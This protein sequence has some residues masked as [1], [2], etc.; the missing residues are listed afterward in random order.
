VL[1]ASYSQRMPDGSLPE[2][3]VTMRRFATP[4]T[5]AGAAALD[6]VEMSFADTFQIGDVVEL[7]VGSELQSMQFTGR[8]T[9]WRP[10]GSMEIHLTPNSVL[11]YQYATSEPN[12]RSAKGYDSAPA[13]LTESGPRFSL[14][15][16]TAV[17]QRA[18]HHEISYSRKFGSN[19]FKVAVYQ[20]NLR[21]AALV[22][23]SRTFGDLSGVLP[24]IYSGTFSYNAGNLSTRGFR[25]VAERR[26][27]PLLTA[28]VTYSYGGV[29]EL[30]GDAPAWLGLS[31]GP[32]LRHAVSGNIRGEAPRTRTR[33]IASYKWTS[34]QSL[35]AVDMF[36]GSPGRADPY[37]NIFIRQP[38]PDS[39]FLPGH[40]EALVDMRNLLAEGYTP[41]IAPDG[42]TIYLVQSVLD[43]KLICQ[44]QEP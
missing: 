4:T 18:R 9:A 41:V 38:L 39:S 30:K 13:D 6:A 32:E 22:G 1:R 31:F 7:K 28:N 10:F 2:L 17:F 24:D 8:V 29:L 44:T 37:L 25:I 33:W 42:R 12:S 15:G 27:S 40:F 36:N 35:S 34:A 16:G 3:A 14:D 43:H 26:I 23:V 19:R 11:E 21:D 5:I 20:D